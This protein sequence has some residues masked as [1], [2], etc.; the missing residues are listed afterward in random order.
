M[1]DIFVL[2]VGLTLRHMFALFLCF[3]YMFDKY[4]KLSLYFPYYDL[5]ISF[6]HTFLFF[7]FFYYQKKFRYSNMSKSYTL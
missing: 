3:C 2:K 1:R 7:I 6:H 5:F 4:E